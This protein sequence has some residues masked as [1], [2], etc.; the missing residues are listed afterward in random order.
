MN[1]QTVKKIAKYVV[2]LLLAL[3]TAY[4]YVDTSCTCGEPGP[5]NVPAGE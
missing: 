5:A 1:P 2:P 4:G 3:G